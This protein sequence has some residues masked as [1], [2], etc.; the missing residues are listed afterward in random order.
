MI[1]QECLCKCVDKILVK[2][3]IFVLV[4][5][6]ITILAE[7]TVCNLCSHSFDLPLDAFVPCYDLID[8]LSERDKI[9]WYLKLEEL[10]E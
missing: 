5:N 10:A 6:Y 3:F 9:L 1:L 2:L 7:N 4:V 8:V